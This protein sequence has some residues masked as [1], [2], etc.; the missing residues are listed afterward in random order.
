VPPVILPQVKEDVKARLGVLRGF[1]S[2]MSEYGIVPLAVGVVIGNAVND[3]VKTLV[4]GLITPFISLVSPQGK[5][6][7]LQ[8]EFHD[9]VFKVGLVLNAIISFLIVALVVYIAAKF[10]L[11]N[12]ALLKKK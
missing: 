3:L 8:I 6:Q 11:K 12:D 2:F 7:G 5:L 4:E 9:S 1:K 10:V